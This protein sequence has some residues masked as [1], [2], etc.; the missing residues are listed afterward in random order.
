MFDYSVAYTMVVNRWLAISVMNQFLAQR[1]QPV[2]AQV[3][4]TRISD[5][6]GLVLPLDNSLYFLFH[7]FGFMLLSIIA[8]K[9]LLYYS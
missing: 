1:I 8:S 9:N 3:R 7:T 5:C 6:I 2:T 4:P